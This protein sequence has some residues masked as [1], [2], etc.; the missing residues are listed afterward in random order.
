MSKEDRVLTLCVI[1]NEGYDCPGSGSGCPTAALSFS[2][3]WDQTGK[4]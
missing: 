3:E 1:V 2:E 4:E